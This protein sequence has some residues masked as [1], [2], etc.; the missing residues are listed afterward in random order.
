M[1]RVNVEAYQS[2]TG[3]VE[4]MIWLKVPEAG[5]DGVLLGVCDSRQAADEIAGAFQRLM[6]AIPALPRVVRPG[7]R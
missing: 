7:I 2:A 1:V 3:A 6:D 4:H 5:N